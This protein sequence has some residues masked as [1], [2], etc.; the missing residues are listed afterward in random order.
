MVAAAQ[1]EA[2]AKAIAMAASAKAS[3]GFLSAGYLPALTLSAGSGA[4]L[5]LERA[6]STA[7]LQSE[8]FTSVRDHAQSSALVAR[9]GGVDEA[10]RPG[11]ARSRTERSDAE[12]GS[13]LD[14]IGYGAK[15]V[16]PRSHLVVHLARTWTDA[17]LPRCACPFARDERYHVRV[18]HDLRPAHD[19]DPTQATRALSLAV[20]E[21]IAVSRGPTAE[22]WCF[23]WKVEDHS[24]RGW[25]PATFVEPAEPLQLGRL[26]EAKA[27][28]TPREEPEGSA[29]SRRRR[30][31][32]V[33]VPA[34]RGRA[35]R[36]RIPVGRGGRSSRGGGGRP[37]G[38]RASG[39]R[40]T[41]TQPQPPPPPEPEPQPQQSQ[42]ASAG[43]RLSP[44][45]QAD[46]VELQA[47]AYKDFWNDGN[48]P[49]PAVVHP[50]TEEL[51][52]PARLAIASQ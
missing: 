46:L 17:D 49:R 15:C 47:R 45:P 18:I 26:A 14:A 13:V 33:H 28:A 10:R 21:I 12:S 39:Q 2:A 34:G 19:L 22:E 11:R 25:F 36:G 29:S 16:S 35:S 50:R 38:G 5:S 37:S 8:D 44:T 30:P 6:A 32:A 52:S 1:A 48:S 51:R 7:S 42:P 43:L 20:G 41:A 27:A 23:G 24:A 3:A 31:A 4:G 40:R 9:G